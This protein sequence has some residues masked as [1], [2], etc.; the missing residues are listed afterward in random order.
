MLGWAGRVAAA[1]DAAGMP[2]TYYNLGIR[3]QTGPEIAARVSTEVPPRLASVDDP[4]LLVSFGANDTVAIDGIPRVTLNESVAALEHIGSATGV[5]LFVVGPPAVENEKQNRRLAELDAALQE[6]AGY[7]GG[8]YVSLFT[9]T[10]VSP[11]WRR[12]IS[13][14][15]GYHPGADGYDLLARITTPHILDWLR[16]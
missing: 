3:G 1:A 12:E 7:R 14:T 10:R 6:S 5:P 4:R 15:D 8:P 11:L 13:A 16:S 2:L 9:P